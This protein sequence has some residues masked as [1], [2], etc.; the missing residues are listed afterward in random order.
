[1]RKAMSRDVHNESII[2]LDRPN[3][4]KQKQPFSIACAKFFNTARQFSESALRKVIFF[5]VEGLG[6]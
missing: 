5:I 2:P 4:P 6:M 1:M 3:I